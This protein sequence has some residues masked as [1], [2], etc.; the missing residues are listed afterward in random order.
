MRSYVVRA[1]PLL[2][3][4]TLAASL[5]ACGADE[6]ASARLKNVEPG[7]TREALLAE[8]GTGP[9][10]GEGADSARVVNGFRRM[11][12]L[13]DGK[14]YEV[15]YARDDAGKVSEALS[16]TLETPVVL[17]GDKVVG[18]GWAYYTKTAMT[19]LRLP[20]PLVGIDSTQL[21]Q[22]PMPPKQDSAAA[23]TTPT[24]P[25]ADGKKM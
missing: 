7:M 20:N 4:A 19:Q 13:V 24:T 17:D 12:Y 10:I 14:Q 1:V 22:P 11:R 5:T 21:P 3:A 9:L 16:A 2:L 15:I 25:P 8:M 6:A 18:K 23:P